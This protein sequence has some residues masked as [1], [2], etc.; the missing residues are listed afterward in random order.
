MS[1]Y[2][3][4]KLTCYLIVDGHGPCSS[5]FPHYFRLSDKKVD[6]PV[7][8]LPEEDI[9]C[10][11]KPKFRVYYT[12][13]VGF[14]AFAFRNICATGS[15]KFYLNSEDVNGVGVSNISHALALLG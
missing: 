2:P 12:T 8:D 7:F 11:S 4:K 9:F 1:A 6:G 14:L 13:R 15:Y 3:N 5:F 10:V